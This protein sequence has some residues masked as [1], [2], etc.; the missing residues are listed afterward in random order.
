MKSFWAIVKQ[1]VR[2]S[3]RTK[4]FH[5]LFLFLVLAVFLLPLTVSGDGTINSLVQVSLLYSLSVVIVLISVTTLWLSCSCL[6]TEIENYTIHTNV[7]KPCARWKIWAGKWCGI[8][9]MNALILLV[10]M[11]A[12]YA[13][14]QWRV[15]RCEKSGRYAPAEIARLHKEILVGRRNFFADKN[16]LQ[17]EVNLEW[18]KNQEKYAGKSEREAKEEIRNQI[19]MQNREIKPG[20]VKD[21]VWRKVKG[22]DDLLF[23]RFRV[24]SGSTGFMDQRDIPCYWGV[25][26]PSAPKSSGDVYAYFP[27]RFRSGTFQEL[28]LDPTCIDTEN[29]NSVKIQFICPPKE[30]V[31][32]WN[33]ATPAPFVMQP[34]DGPFLMMAAASFTENYLRAVI[35]ALIQIAFLAALGCA[36]SAAFSTPVAVFVAIAYLLIG[37]TVN[38]AIS[39]PIMDEN[40]EYQYQNVGERITHYV[41]RAVGAIIVSVD[42]LNITKPLSTGY[43]ISNGRLIHS[44]VFYLLFRTGLITFCGIWIFYKRELGL[45]MRK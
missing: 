30:D 32:A 23:L 31:E 21:W 28:M 2:S 11:G 36:V 6:S 25:R 27:M 7:T 35:L 9:G 3:V 17:K 12:I 19:M 13:L 45:V 5:V 4:V 29:D 34:E 44:F 14:V 26:D 10:S 20:D 22:Q 33:G 40:G 42:D 1:T 38:L 37:M 39:A 24:Y 15:H 18:E 16:I 41:S 8:F 43:W